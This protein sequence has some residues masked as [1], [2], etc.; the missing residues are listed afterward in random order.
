MRDC[1]D[2]FRRADAGSISPTAAKTASYT[3]VATD[4]GKT[5]SNA[6]AGGAVVF[7]LPTA[8]DG[9]FFRFLRHA[10]QDVTITATG[11][12]KIN[13]SAA[14]GS[15][16]LHGGSA[17]GALRSVLVWSNGTDWYLSESLPSRIFVSAEQTGTGSS[18]DIAH[19]LGVAPLA[20]F[21]TPTDLNV[22]TVGDYTVTPGTHDTTNVKVT[23]TANK[24]FV[25]IAIAD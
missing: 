21:F 24:K 18:Q 2:G 10:A 19:G 25:A 7:T 13:G 14:N 5:F 4:A 22:S 12:A 17:P 9:M 1:G 8:K 11:G 20:V 15:Y 16:L 23:V 3:I 6:A